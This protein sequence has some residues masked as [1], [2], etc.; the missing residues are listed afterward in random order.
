MNADEAARILRVSKWTIY[1]WIGRGYFPHYRFG[2]L[3]RIRRTDLLAR[4]EQERR[5]GAVPHDF[6]PGV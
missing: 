5:T 2:R 3:V 1:E 4:I 6:K